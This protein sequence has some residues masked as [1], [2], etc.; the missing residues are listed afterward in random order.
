MFTRDLVAAKRRPVMVWIHGGNF[1]RGSA[2]E[3]EPDYIMDEEVVLVTIQY[4]LGM[5]G[6][7]STED[8]YAGGNYGLMDQVC[9]EQ[10]KKLKRGSICQ[11]CA[12]SKHA[13]TPEVLATTG[14]CK[15]FQLPD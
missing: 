10:D 1:I 15:D 9:K 3:Y 5:F 14:I 13:K 11:R 4:R 2:A 6:F 12:L 7:L 8:Q